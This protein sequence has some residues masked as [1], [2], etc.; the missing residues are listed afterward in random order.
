ML[1]IIVFFNSGD[2]RYWQF[3][4]SFFSPTLPLWAS[5][6]IPKDLPSAIPENSHS[7]MLKH[8]KSGSNRSSFWPQPG[9]IHSLRLN[10]YKVDPHGFTQTML[11]RNALLDF[12]E[13]LGKLLNRHHSQ[14][15]VLMATEADSRLVCLHHQLFAA[16][17]AQH[18]SLDLI[19]ILVHL[20]GK[21]DCHTTLFLKIPFTALYHIFAYK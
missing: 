8:V 19:R 20:H 14:F 10:R 12:L 9:L 13:R 7:I 3:W 2:Y 17:R 11:L 5:I 16:L 15:T 18:Q 6:R 1:P 4:Q 21:H